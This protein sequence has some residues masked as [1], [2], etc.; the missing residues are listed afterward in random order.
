MELKRAKEREVGEGDQMN[1]ASAPAPGIMVRGVVFE[2]KQA[3]V[4]KKQR[5]TGMEMMWV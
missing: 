4:E 2:L 5:Q 3:E 1:N